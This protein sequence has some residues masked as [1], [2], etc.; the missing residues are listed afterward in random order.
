MNVLSLSIR[1]TNPH[2]FLTHQWAR[3]V[4]VMWVQP[5]PR[6]EGRAAYMAVWPNGEVDYIPVCDLGNYEL[7]PT[8][9]VL[10]EWS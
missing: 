3:I 1:G 2:S 10:G 9:A 4:G 8:E 7:A 6:L 5:T